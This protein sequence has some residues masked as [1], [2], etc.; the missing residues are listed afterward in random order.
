MIREVEEGKKKI[1]F[2][3]IRKLARLYKRPLTVFFTDKIISKGVLGGETR[4][5]LVQ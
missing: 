1:G 2:R 3:E 5:L 4:I